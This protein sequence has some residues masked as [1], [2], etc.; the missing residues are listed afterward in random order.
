MIRQLIQRNKKPVTVI[1]IFVLIENVAW[2]IEP[3]FFGKLLDALIDKFYQHEKISY[4][5]PLLLWI[6]VYMINFIGGSLSR[7]YNGRTY[8]RMY[9][10]LAT[11]VIMNAKRHRFSASKMISRADLAREYVD[12]LEFSLPDIS[13]QLTATLGAVCAL[14]FY[15]YRIGMVCLFVII[16]MFL[17][18]NL[19]RKHVTKLQKEVHDNREE[20]YKK[21]E[22]RDI[23]NIDAYYQ[24]MVRPQ[25]SIAKW[26]S[27][28]FGAVKFLLMFVFILVLFICVDV[29][30]FSTGRIYSIV[31]YLWTFIT[32]TDYLPGLMESFTSVKDLNGRMKEMYQTDQTKQKNAPQE[33]LS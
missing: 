2:I 13:W 19:Y 7:F 24:N 29:D 27:F 5:L 17:I 20:I 12:F 32:A 31:S 15:D 14:F 8:P 26:N 28:D 21:L 6:I 10:N 1:M 30:K 4:L 18:N 25:R 23:E 16:P 11:E 9:A 3:T 22:H 33:S